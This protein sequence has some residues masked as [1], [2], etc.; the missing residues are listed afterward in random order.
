MSKVSQ[1]RYVTISEERFAFASS[2][3]LETRRSTYDFIR[4][5]C[6]RSCTNF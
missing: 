5:S 1:F 3:M 2:F 4:G 6:S